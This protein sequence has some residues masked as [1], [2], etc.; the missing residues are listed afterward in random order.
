MILS[1][2]YG[3]GGCIQWCPI[4][5]FTIVIRLESY[6]GS[7]ESFTGLLLEITIG[8][9]HLICPPIQGQNP[10]WNKQIISPG[11]MGCRLFSSPADSAW[12]NSR[13]S[14]EAAIAFCFLINRYLS[15]H[16]SCFH[17]CLETEPRELLPTYEPLSLSQ[18]EAI[19]Q[20]PSFWLWGQVQ[21]TWS[22]AKGGHGF[23]KL[24]DQENLTH[25]HGHNAKLNEMIP[26]NLGSWTCWERQEGASPA[27][28]S[29]VFL[30][31]GK[32]EDAQISFS[33]DNVCLELIAC[34]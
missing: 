28:R 11:C 21:C 5:H 19:W 26:G 25:P 14:F 29:R 15:F 12:G 7:K 8:V 33:S 13:E 27:E 20:H 4:S 16:L 23:C 9:C 18:P 3:V 2:K 30:I 32:F 31:L 1:T 17:Q 10:F 22:D 24:S 34:S 6:F